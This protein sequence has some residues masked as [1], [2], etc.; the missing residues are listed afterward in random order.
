MGGIYLM[1]EEFD[2]LLVEMRERAKFRVRLSG[3]EAIGLRREEMVIK[4]RYASY[5]AGQFFG[6]LVTKL[7]IYEIS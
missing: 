4:I 6:L 2:T 1:L 3:L 7:D 5:F